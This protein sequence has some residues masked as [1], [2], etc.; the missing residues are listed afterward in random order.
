MGFV[1]SSVDAQPPMRGAAASITTP[2]AHAATPRVRGAGARNGGDMR[3][4]WYVSTTPPSTAA[5]PD[6]M[7]ASDRIS[8]STLPAAAQPR[9]R[10]SSTPL[11]T[12]LSTGGLLV[13]GGCASS[14][15]GQGQSAQTGPSVNRAPES[16]AAAPMGPPGTST[17]TLVGSRCKGGVCTCRHPQNV[18][19]QKE[20]EPPDEDHK[21]FEIRLGAEGGPASLSS[22]TLGTFNAGGEG[23]S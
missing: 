16:P 12:A 15:P 6:L 4:L 1:T 18:K 21:R 13:L 8:P 10:R 17:A 19:D 5:V 23:E 3:K 20:A 22:P 11:L 7:S 2:R 14:T 9:R